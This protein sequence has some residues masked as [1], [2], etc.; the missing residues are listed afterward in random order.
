VQ[1][2]VDLLFDVPEKIVF[3]IFDIG[4]WVEFAVFTALMWIWFVIASC[5]GINRLNRWKREKNK[6]YRYGFLRHGSLV[7]G[8]GNPVGVS[9]KARLNPLQRLHNGMI[10]VDK[11][12]DQKN[13]CQVFHY[14]ADL[15]S[16][17][18]V[19]VLPIL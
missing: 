16:W 2:L 12:K 17:T 19:G 5:L 10:Y 9:G 4:E 3:A 1:W 8:D 13:H 18:R 11:T 14:R 7:G 6:I 15:K